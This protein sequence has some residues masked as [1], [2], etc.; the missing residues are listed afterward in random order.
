MDS[1]DDYVHLSV[2]YPPKIAVSNLVNSLKGVSRRLLRKERPDIQKRY[3]QGGW[4][5]PSYF[6]LSCGGAPISIVRRYIEQQQT[7][8][9]TSRAATPSALSFPALNGGACRAPSQGTVG[10]AVP[11]DAARAFPLR[12]WAVVVAIGEAMTAFENAER[13][14]LTRRLS[15]VSRVGPSRR[16]RSGRP[17]DRPGPGR[18]TRHIA[19]AVAAFFAGLA[20]RADDR[21][22][23]SYRVARASSFLGTAPDR[24]PCDVA[25][26]SVQR[27]A[28][29]VRRPRYPLDLR[30]VVRARTTA[31]VAIKPP[32]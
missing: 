11:D 17:T 18:A 24:V 28:V 31:A 1:E 13:E 29:L 19:L 16:D 12:I 26:P 5:S 3:W 27:R 14:G 8:P 10:E 6:A 22:R 23:L 20:V 30:A 9:E 2:E 32:H 15:P 25:F 21:A 7:L 4:W